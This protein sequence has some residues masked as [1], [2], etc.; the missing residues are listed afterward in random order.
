MGPKSR[1]HQFLAKDFKLRIGFQM[2]IFFQLRFF[3]R[4]MTIA[5]TI[6]IT[7]IAA[8]IRIYLRM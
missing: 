7:P 8:K 3:G 5:S 1:F 4:E 6:T 2:L